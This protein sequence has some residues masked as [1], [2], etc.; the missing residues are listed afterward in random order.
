MKN[1]STLRLAILGVATGLFLTSQATAADVQFSVDDL[2]TPCREGLNASRENEEAAAV[3][4]QQYLAGFRDASVMNGASNLCFPS[5]PN[6]VAEMQR[7]YVAW[8]V[9]SGSSVRDWPAAKGMST[10]FACRY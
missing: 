1:P 7:D 9:Q 3:E 5:G 4:C 6:R 10:A 8:A 2:L